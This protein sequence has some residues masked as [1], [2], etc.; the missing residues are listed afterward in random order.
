MLRRQLLNRVPLLLAVFTMAGCS[1]PRLERLAG[2]VMGTTWSVQIVGGVQPGLEAQVQARLDAIDARMTTYSATS[3]LARFNASDST[4]WVSVSS[5]LAGVVAEALRVGELTGGAFDITAGPLVELWGFGA[6]ST[7]DTLPAPH[8]V[9]ALRERVSVSHVAV[10]TTPAALR[11][12]RPDVALDLS[13][14]AKGYAVDQI[15]DLLE[16]LGVARYLVE[17]GGELRGRGRNARG[18]LWQIAVEQPAAGVRRVQR[19]FP[20]RDLAVATSGDYRNFFELNGRRYSHTIDP[21]SG[22][23]VAH[24]LASV[25]VLDPSAMSADAFATGLLVLGE[26][27]GYA[28]AL[29]HDIPALFVVREDTGYRE[30]ITPRFTALTASG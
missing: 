21:R 14:L 4:Q 3:E 13:A 2:A 18:E 23:P 1:E 22:Y 19:A 25:T 7:I 27:A 24:R 17:V 16:D 12:A 26:D 10:R 30:R 29:A 8:T 28:F 5:E 20:L 6:A 11:K 9:V 15:A